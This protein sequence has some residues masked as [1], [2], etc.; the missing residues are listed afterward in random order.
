MRVLFVCTA[1][2]LR[3]PTAEAVF[4]EHP[5]LEVLSHGTDPDAPTPLTRKLVA[6]ADLVIAMETQHCERIRKKYKERPAD[7]RIV[8][9]HI[10]DAPGATA[11]NLKVCRS[12]VTR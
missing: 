7:S 6:S 5:G 11:N 1:N 12:I 3:S 4:R 9:L 10:S 8:T 2:K